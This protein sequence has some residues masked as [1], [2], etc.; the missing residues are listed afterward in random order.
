MHRAT[1]HTLRPL[2][3]LG[4][5]ALICAGLLSLPAAAGEIYQWKDAQGVTHYADSPPANREY[6]NRSVTGSGPAT[7]VKAG[8]LKPAENEQCATA[9]KNLTQLQ[10]DAPVGFDAD[11][12]GKL[13]SVM[14]ATQRAAQA[15][16]AQAAINVHCSAAVTGGAMA[17]AGG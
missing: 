13:D 17:Q 3:R 1:R 15:Q 16:L 5:A 11:K 8:E 12:D 2:P 10:G 7:V 14:D 9:R 4:A 6:K